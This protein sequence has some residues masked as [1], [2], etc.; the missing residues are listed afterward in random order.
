[1]SIRR[2]G[3]GVKVSTERIPDSQ[4]VLEIEVEPERLEKSMNRAYR[5][6]AQRASVPGFRKGK[7]PR[8]ML[9]RY[10]GAGAIREEALRLLIPEVC[11]EAIEGQQII[12]VDVPSVEVVREEP[13]VIKATV[14]VWPEVDLGNYREVRVERQP[15]Q[16]SE[17]Q[18]D[19]KVEELR[20]RYA[21]LEPLDRPVQ[22]GDLVR[23]DVKATVD[24]RTVYSEEDAEFRLR[25]GVTILLP[26]VC[27]QLPG[28]E[29]SVERQISVPVPEDNPDRSIAGKECL[30]TFLVKEI[31]E[32]KLPDLN[33]DFAREVGEGFSSLAAL[34][35]RLES[36]LRQSAET[37]AE[38]HYRDKVVD[39]V[40]AGAT[41][42]LPSVVVEREADRLLQ[43]QMNATGVQDVK[44]YLERL[45][46]PEDQ[47]RQEL[48]LQATD[49]VQRSLVLSR[50][51]E[52]E[53]I[54]V[55]EEDVE[56]EIERLAASSGPQADEVRRMFSN[57]DGRG[58]LE[59]S[60][61]TRKTL[62][63]LMAIASDQEVPPPAQG[64]EEA[65]EEESSKE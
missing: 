7:T 59:R 20:H 42:E 6:L 36:D 8:A 33:D 47:L 64:E 22:M 29:K 2:S 45:R 10:L 1:M 11:Q 9:E 19:E 3:S 28:T 18:V 30:C 4:V 25:E 35:E 49:R 54:S 65:D 40:V 26:G 50:V 14:P 57:P 34:R 44:S 27:E 39:A 5:Q 63:R 62:D 16:V 61:L 32:E 17:E 41:L 58:A 24:G 13:L 23:A 51:A 48:R 52:L 43:D 21:T 60:L 46:K 38:A 12:A 53:G 37:V 55:N 15:A 31:K 56:A